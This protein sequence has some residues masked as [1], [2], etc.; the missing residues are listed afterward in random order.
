M[1]RR[2]VCFALVAAWFSNI[3]AAAPP[4][5]AGLTFV[6]WQDPIAC[7]GVAVFPD[8]VIV[9]DGDGAVLILAGPG[10]NGGDAFEAAGQLHRRG[11]A[12][13][14][15]FVGEPEALPADAA[16]AYRRFTD[17]GGLTV[18]DIP[19]DQK[20][21]L[22]IDGFFGIGLSRRIG[23]P[24]KAPINTA[25]SLAERKR[26]PLLALDCPS[27]INGDSGRLHGTGIRASHT[28]SFIGA[29]PGLFMADGPDHCGEISIATLDLDAASLAKG[30]SGQTIAPALFADRLRPRLRN[31]HKG[32]YGNAGI[33]GG[34]RGM[35]GAA[36]LAA[37]AA[38]RLGS[39]KVFVGLTDPQ[40]RARLVALSA[41]LTGVA[42]AR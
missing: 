7:G 12:T 2:T 11:F 5:V 33:I 27:G 13:C 10:N 1:D 25:N 31:S 20:W 17:T 38:L 18:T 35:T 16:A 4:S 15:V 23:A 21:A 6:G 24:Y 8:D 19:A 39:G 37:R 41:E 14:V 28:I 26:I 9:L 3:A 34:A 29:K 40:A 22:I 42:A 30:A 36:L 32:L